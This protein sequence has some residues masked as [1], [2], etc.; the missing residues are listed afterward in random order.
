[1]NLAFG[2][3]KRRELREAA[4]VA[5]RAFDDYEYFTNWFPEKQSRNRIQFALLWGNS[6]RISAPRSILWAD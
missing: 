6:G 1:M 4:E 2:R 5:T 3:M